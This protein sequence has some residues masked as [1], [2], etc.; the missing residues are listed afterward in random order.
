LV[1]G[2]LNAVDLDSYRLE[3]NEKKH[4]Q[5]EGDIVLD[6]SSA[7]VGGA[8]T[9][10]KMEYLSEI[11]RDFYEKFGKNITENDSV[12]KFMLEELP[13]QVVAHEEYQNTKKYSDR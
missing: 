10:L 4:I 2:V 8:I 12:S 13:R 5:L 3:Q 6:P 9:D 11:V 1:E 7:N